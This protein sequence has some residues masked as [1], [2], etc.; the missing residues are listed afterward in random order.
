LG[1]CVVVVVVVVVEVVFVVEV[2]EVVDF[3][4][5]KLLLETQT[6]PKSLEG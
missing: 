1:G 6:F 4:D 5:R 3:D 2:V